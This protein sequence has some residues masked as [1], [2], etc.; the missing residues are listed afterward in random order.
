MARSKS[1][2][3]PVGR[4]F[5]RKKKSRAKKNGLRRYVWMFLAFITGSGGIAGATEYEVLRGL[6]NIVRD[7]LQQQPL[8]APAETPAADGAALRVYFTRPDQPPRAGDIAHVLA[9]YVDQARET[10]DVCA[11]ELDNRVITDALVRAA[12]RGV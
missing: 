8:V 2:P 11:F 5:G 9:G 1:S 10:L 4:L 12:R 3:G 7:R 6:W